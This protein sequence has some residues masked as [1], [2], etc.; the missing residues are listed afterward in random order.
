MDKNTIKEIM[1]KRGFR[2]LMETLKGNKLHSIVFCTEPETSEA[3]YNCEVFVD[4]GDFKFTYNSGKNLNILTTPEC[5]SF[6]NDEHFERINSK[7]KADVML[8][9][10]GGTYE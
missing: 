9:E 1:A 5:G 3:L 2:Q 4:E 8:L 6:E 7:F 10:R